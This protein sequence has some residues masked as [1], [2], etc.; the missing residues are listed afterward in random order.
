MGMFL[1]RWKY[2]RGL[3]NRKKTLLKKVQQLYDYKVTYG[4][5]PEV[6]DLALLKQLVERLVNAG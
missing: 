2:L 4:T 1:E 3:E 5:M 6:G